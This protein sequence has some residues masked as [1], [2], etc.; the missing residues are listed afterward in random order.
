MTKEEQKIFIL[1]DIIKR[2]CYEVGEERLKDYRKEIYNQA[3]KDFAEKMNTM[4]DATDLR[5]NGYYIKNLV[6]IAKKELK[7]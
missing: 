6:R 1:V 3:L 7:K 2:N 5:N 4:L